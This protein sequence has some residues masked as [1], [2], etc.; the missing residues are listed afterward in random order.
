MWSQVKR[1]INAAACQFP[2]LRLYLL[3]GEANK[4]INLQAFKNLMT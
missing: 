4:V 3:A 1:V 2:N